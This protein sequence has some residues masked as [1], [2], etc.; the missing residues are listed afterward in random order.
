VVANLFLVALFLSRDFKPVCSFDV[1]NFVVDD[2]DCEHGGGGDTIL[3]T[4]DK[5][6]LSSNLPSCHPQKILLGFLWFL[7]F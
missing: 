1:R 6:Q 4:R 3:L 5:T 7:N 2:I